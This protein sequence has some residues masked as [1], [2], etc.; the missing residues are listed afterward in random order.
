MKQ[1]LVGLSILV[2]VS[3]ILSFTGGVNN[4]QPPMLDSKDTIDQKKE[5][6][7]KMAVANWD[8]FY[9]GLSITASELRQSDRPS[10][11]VAFLIDSVIIPLQQ[12]IASQLQKQIAA[13]PK[14][15]K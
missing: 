10:K 8:K 4:T 9:Q 2:L 7:V 11:N 1:I 12:Q 15:P 5:Y 13:D 3:I 14:K 6:P